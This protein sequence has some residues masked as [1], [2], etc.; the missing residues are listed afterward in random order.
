MI[1]NVT[2]D[3]GV[4]AGKM[5]SLSGIASCL[6]K[7]AFIGSCIANFVILYLVVST[8][9]KKIIVKMDSFRWG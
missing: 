4:E 2:N 3:L 7:T 5:W 1:Y 9:I 6:K 8:H